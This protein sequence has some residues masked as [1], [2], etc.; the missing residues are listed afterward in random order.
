VEASQAHLLAGQL[1]LA[2]RRRQ[3]ADRHL[4]AAARGRQRGP[5]MPRATGWLAEALRAEAAGDPRRLLAACRRGLDVLDQHRLTLGAAELRARATAHGAELAMLAQ[6]HAVRAARPRLLL[7]WSERWR[8]TALAVPPVRPPD[9][10]E[11][12]TDLAALR[13]VTSRL[14]KARAA[15]GPAAVLAREQLRLEAAV[16]ARVLRTP[17]AA[18]AGRPAFSVPELLGALGPAR[19]LQII[20]VDGTLQVLVCGGGRVRQL[21][22]G[23]SQDAGRESEFVRFGLQRLA[24]RRDRDDQRASVAVLAAGARKLEAALLGP[25]VRQ[26]G[27]GP[28]VIV[29]PARLHAVP[30]ALLPSLRDRVISVAPS[31]TA[32]LRARAIGAP[33]GR[34][35]VV[36]CGPGL[37]AGAQEV[38]AVAGEYPGA[39]VLTG[40]AAT[41]AKVLEAIDGAWLAHI[42]AHGTFRADSPLFSSLLLDDGLLTVYDF[43]RLRRAPYRLVLSSCDSGLLAPAGADELL[44]LA[45]SLLPLGTAGILA[46][47]VPLNDLAAAALMPR[48]HRSLASGGT[49]A[50]SLPVVRRDLGDDPLLLGAGW[51]L[52]ALGAA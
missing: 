48:L 45:S 30:W 44:G 41:A 4:A 14:E 32:W 49:L 15:D 21:A 9:D 35:V 28:L 31:A 40:G 11:L 18:G 33:S 20:D 23:R 39:R 3:D 36:A 26:L 42:A 6:R 51:S 7:S 24:R 2:R 47:V 16:R 34:Q 37:A 8:A 50:E 43:E 10:R 22:A 27:D 12:G 46:S 38:P 19:L 13:D 5:A 52:V 25:A 1:A 29:P 17:G